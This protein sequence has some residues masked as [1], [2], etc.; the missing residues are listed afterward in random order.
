MQSR[1][2]HL[3]QYKDPAKGHCKGLCTLLDEN[4]RANA[5]YS[6]KCEFIH[7]DSGLWGRRERR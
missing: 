7:V 6:P 4:A 1:G 2:A 5:A 3:Q